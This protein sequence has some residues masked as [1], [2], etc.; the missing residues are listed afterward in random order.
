M[1]SNAH[2]QIKTQRGFT[3]IE[4]VVVLVVL[5]LLAAVAVPKF[6]EVTKQAEASSV[7]G[8]L[9]NLRNYFVGWAVPT[10]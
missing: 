2:T 8:V 7:R 5:S 1:Q 3:L 6:I 4:L 10:C 9:G